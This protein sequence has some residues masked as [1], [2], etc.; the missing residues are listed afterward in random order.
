LP[1][2]VPAG[3]AAKAADADGVTATTDSAWTDSAR[4]SETANSALAD[5]AGVVGVV[6]P[7]RMDATGL[8]EPVAPGQAETSDVLAT[9][10]S[11]LAEMDG[12]VEAVDPALVTRLFGQRAAAAQ[13]YADRLVTTG[14]EWGLIGPAEVSRIWS[15]HLVNSV[16][17]ADIVP[18]G[19]SVIDVGSGAGLPGI[20][21]ALAR[22]DLRLTLLEPMQ[23]RCRFLA[24]TVAELDLSDQIEVVR[25][26]AETYAGTADVVIARAVAGLDKLIR[27][28]RQLWTGGQLLA[29]K[30]DRATAEIEAAAPVL[31]RWKLR[32]DL[33][34]LPQATVVRVA[35]V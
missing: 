18:M 27:L 3:G 16:A 30:G 5:T 13:R 33:L 29:F 19:A 21:L 10:D 32:A 1:E 12:G 31:K 7:A 17:V 9:A 25:D 26:R 35:R 15:R 6:D 8:I 23:R 28:T 11:V 14:L 4:E 24:D 22:P 20:P 34:Y 2:S